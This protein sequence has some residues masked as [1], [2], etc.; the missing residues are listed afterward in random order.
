[1]GYAAAGYP[2]SDLVQWEPDLP[3]LLEPGAGQDDPGKVAAGE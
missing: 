3:R 2:L 1:M